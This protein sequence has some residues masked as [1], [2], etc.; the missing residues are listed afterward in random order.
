MLL[1]I[2]ELNSE[3]FNAVVIRNHSGFNHDTF[4]H[5]ILHSRI[6]DEVY[7][8]LAGRWLVAPLRFSVVEIAAQSA[9]DILLGGR[10][11]FDTQ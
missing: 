9:E 8:R 7:Q 6:D 4:F 5:L 1:F 10:E 2:T 11:S 3:D